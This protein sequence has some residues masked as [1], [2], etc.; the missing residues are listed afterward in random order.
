MLPNKEHPMKLSKLLFCVATLAPIV[1]L[2]SSPARLLADTYTIQSLDNDAG[3]YFYGM[4]DSGHVVFL[5]GDTFLCGPAASACYETISEGSLFDYSS[6][7]PTFAWDYVAG[8]CV[9]PQPFSAPCTISNNGRTAVIAGGQ[10]Q[11]TLSVYSGSNPPQ[12]LLTTGFGGIFAMNGLGDIVFDNGTVDG[13]YEAIDLST[14][15]AISSASAPVPAD[16]PEPTS[17]LLLGT[18]VIAFA[19]MVLR[20]KRAA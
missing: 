9:Y 7:A 1:S 16:V 8:T 17:I 3:R 4:D 10:S 15:P 18:G 19:G 13:W 5:R 14:A 20:R 6:V 11:E 2:S 12:L